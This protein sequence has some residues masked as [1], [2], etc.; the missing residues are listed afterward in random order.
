M[1]EAAAGLAILDVGG[2]IVCL[3]EVPPL[4]KDEDEEG[5][6]GT[7]DDDD[8]LYDEPPAAGA[9]IWKPNRQGYKIFPSFSI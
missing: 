7:A 6:E 5:R 4:V 1:L 9:A 2:L 8:E 3:F